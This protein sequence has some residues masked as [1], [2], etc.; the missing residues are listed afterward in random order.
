[1]RKTL[2]LV[3]VIGVLLVAGVALGASLV[4]TFLA[5][6]GGHYNAANAPATI[7]STFQMN[8]TYEWWSQPFTVNATGYTMTMNCTS[9]YG[10]DVFLMNSTRFK[11]LQNNEGLDY[12]F[13]AE[14]TTGLNYSYTPGAVQFALDS[15]T[16]Y[17]RV[18]MDSQ[19]GLP[20]Y[21]SVLV[22]YTLTITPP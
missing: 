2:P 19:V 18:F 5:P 6:I 11:N 3:T 15:Q 21:I 16:T 17:Y 1:M 22:N 20:Y 12:L 14:N 7:S 8:Y 13:F 9:N 10:V 4:V